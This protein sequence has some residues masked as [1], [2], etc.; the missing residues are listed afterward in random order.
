MTPLAMESLLNAIRPMRWFGDKNAVS[1]EFMCIDWALVNTQE[2]W[3]CL[4][5]LLLHCSSDRRY[6]FLIKR[7]CLTDIYEDASYGSELV[8][9]LCADAG[10]SLRTHAGALLTFN[11]QETLAHARVLVPLEKDMTTNTLFKLTTAAD[12]W[13]VKFYRTLSISNEHEVSVLKALSIQ[14]PSY[15]IAG[16]IEYHLPD[17]EMSTSFTLA[18]VNK[19][20]EGLPAYKLYSRSIKALFSRIATGELE[21][22]SSLDGIE[23]LYQLSFTIGTQ[24]AF[25]H[26]KIN[27]HFV[28]H[29]KQSFNLSGYIQCNRNRWQRVYD[30]VLQDPQLDA[31]ARATLCAYLQQGYT[32][33]LADGFAQNHSSIDASIFHGDLHLSHIFINPDDITHCLLID[34]SPRSLDECEKEFSTQ[35]ALQDLKNLHRGLDYFSYD[36]I[37][38]DLAGKMKV[39]QLTV[40]NTLWQQPDLIAREYPAHYYLLCRWSDVVFN[41]ILKGYVAQQINLDDQQ[42]SVMQLFYFCRLLKEMEYNYSFDR[43]FFKYCDYFFLRKLVESLAAGN[44]QSCVATDTHIMASAEV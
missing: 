18:V 35:S 37:I 40:A 11:A 33:Y 28:R 32:H 17:G 43:T 25:F 4:W 29:G 30:A 10:V 20:I 19:F 42:L 38:D 44:E 5:V 1:T 16:T 21:Q 8:D 26:N 9:L 24:T 27:A 3:H 15:R 13:A 22:L 14:S 39:S 12:D 23:D 34:P 6:S 31:M 2:D 36:E 41:G 7:N